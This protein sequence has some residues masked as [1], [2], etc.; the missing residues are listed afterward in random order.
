MLRFIPYRQ[1]IEARKQ[2]RS[3]WDKARDRLID[4]CWPEIQPGFS[5]DRGARIFTIGSCFARNIEEHLARLGFDIPMLRVSVPPVEWRARPN[6]ILNKFTPPSI[7][8][9]IR[10]AA[11]VEAAGGKV[12][13]SNCEIFAYRLSDGRVI[14]N[15]LAGYEPV[16]AERFLE[17]R[18]H[19]FD[20]VREVFRSDCVVITPGLIEAWYDSKRQIYIQKAPVDRALRSYQDQ[21]QFVQLDY[22]TALK[23][24]QDTIDLIRSRRPAARFLLTTSP[25][26]LASTFTQEDVIVANMHAKSTLRAVCGELTRNNDG[27][28]YFPSY[29]SVMLTRDWKIFED[30]LIH[31]TDAFVGKIVARLAETYFGAASEAEKLFQ[32]SSARIV[33]GQDRQLATNLDSARRACELEPKRADFR[34]H[35]GGLLLRSGKIDAAIAELLRAIEIDPALGA[36]HRSLAIAYEKSDQDELALRHMQRA[37]ELTPRDANLQAS[38]ARLQMKFGK[39]EIAEAT[40]AAARKLNPRSAESLFQTAVLF[41]RQGRLADAL[42]AAQRAVRYRPDL[43]RYHVL[44]RSLEQAARQQKLERPRTS[45]IE[46]VAAALG[47]LGL[48]FRR[49]VD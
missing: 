30:D 37:V 10:W 12:S 40:L 7:Y 11:D 8:Q 35:L 28:D 45:W 25:V 34:A 44:L 33:T 16:S 13:Q 46:A 3:Q 42:A 5:L 41:N 22:A 9:E 39:L 21:I 24:L 18:Q 17:R 1:A 32:D 23:Y 6:G 2:T 19:I 43:K 47:R 26:P 48:R 14:D 38:L 27:V 4:G 20:V 49:A 29:E 36:A 31:V 15:A